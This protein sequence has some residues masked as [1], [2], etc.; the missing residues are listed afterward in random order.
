MLSHM[1]IR[2]ERRTLVSSSS[3]SKEATIG[4]TAKA[5]PEPKIKST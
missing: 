5:K 2:V 1:P 4:I 3:A